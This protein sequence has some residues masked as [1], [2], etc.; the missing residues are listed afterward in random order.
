MLRTRLVGVQIRLDNIRGHGECP[1]CGIDVENLDG[2]IS[3]AL[4][5]LDEI[6]EPKRRV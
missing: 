6:V 5:R 4:S 2:S 3:R 1:G